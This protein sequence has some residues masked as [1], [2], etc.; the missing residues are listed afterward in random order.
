M[1]QWG[2]RLQ[3]MVW[4]LSDILFPRHCHLCETAM[5]HH[6]RILL[7]ESCSRKVLF[8]PRSA[9]RGC[10]KFFPGIDLS[11]DPHEEKIFCSNC[12]RTKRFFD[13]CFAVST[14]EGPIKKLIQSFKYTREEYL[15]RTLQTFF[16]KVLEKSIDW[17]TFDWIVPVPLHPLKLKERGFNQSLILA[18]A[19][20]C[21]AGI[22]LLKRG[23][24][25]IKYSPGQTLQDKRE[26]ME[27]IQDSFCA[28]SLTQLSNKKVLLVDDVLTTEATAQECSKILK[29][30][31]AK[32]VTVLVLAR[33][34]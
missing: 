10:A 33:S 18:E 27:N 32:G 13:E 3:K 21:K 2:S 8:L 19:L 30:A 34:V 11:N 15:A 14:Y 29:Q 26:R 5:P 28:G 17:K 4:I 31:G 25:R 24:R 20:S 12:S 16:L 22:P 6:H 1:S 7:C 23:L 9:C